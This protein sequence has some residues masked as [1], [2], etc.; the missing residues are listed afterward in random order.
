MENSTKQDLKMLK[1]DY[2]YSTNYDYHREHSCESSGCYDEGICRCCQIEDAYVNSIDLSSLTQEIYFQ[3]IP[4]NGKSRKRETRISEILYGGPIV[5]QY[6]IYRILVINKVFDTGYWEV[7]ICGGYYGQEI[8]DVTIDA[9][10]LFKINEQ[11]E[12]LFQLETLSE[13]LRCS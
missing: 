9:S 5:D 1:L 11:C 13:K 3:F 2:T 10:L 4:E 7:N 12:K 8:D 6:C